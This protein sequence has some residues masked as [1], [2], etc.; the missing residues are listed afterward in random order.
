MSGRSVWAFIIAS[1]YKA[2]PDRTRIFYRTCEKKQQIECKVFLCDSVIGH[3]CPQVHIG[4]CV[5]PQER[6]HRTIVE[7]LIIYNFQSLVNREYGD[8]SFSFSEY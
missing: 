7:L 3:A 8:G 5:G 2:H 1:H 6:E 4:P